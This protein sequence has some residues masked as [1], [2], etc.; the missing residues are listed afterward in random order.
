MVAQGK[1]A[2]DK[3]PDS[4]KLTVDIDMIVDVVLKENMAKEPEEVRHIVHD[5]H[6]YKMLKVCKS[7]Q[8]KPCQHSAL[9]HSMMKTTSLPPCSTPWI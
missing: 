8:V 1:G 4:I 9:A 5:N 6:T 3:L 2:A 7:R